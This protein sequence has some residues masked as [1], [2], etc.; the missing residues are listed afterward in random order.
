MTQNITPEPFSCLRIAVSVPVKE[1]FFYSVPESLRGLVRLGSRVLVP[2]IV[3][4]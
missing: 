1:T 4:A 3:V 2:L